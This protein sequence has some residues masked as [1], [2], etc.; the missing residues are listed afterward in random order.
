MVALAVSRASAECTERTRGLPWASTAERWTPRDG[1]KV[2]VRRAQSAVALEDTPE[3]RDAA[4]LDLAM[5]L[6]M[7]SRVRDGVSDGDAR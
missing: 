6:A 3:G 2:S 1:G 5:R 4:I 7:M